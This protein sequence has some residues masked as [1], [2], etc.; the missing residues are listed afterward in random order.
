MFA[1]IALPLP[2]RQTFTYR[3]PG[4]MGSLA[5]PGCR[6]VVPF[7]RK[8]QTGFIVS[9]SEALE[10]EVPASSIKEVEEL[11][12]EAPIVP[13]DILE[14]TRWMADY[15]YAPWGEALRAALP[16]GSIA[17][18]EQVLELTEAGREALIVGRLT[19]SKRQALELLSQSGSTTTQEFA[20]LV[21]AAGA[22]GASASGL[23]KKLDREGFVRVTQKV[24]E[25]RL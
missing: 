25:S 20:R 9:L 2:L 13:P 7:G 24:G 19:P 10:G 6:V 3:L 4:D 15:Y 22:T 8:L 12:D 5:S 21:A 14:L 1:E 17:L 23:I 16:G 18:T 11:V